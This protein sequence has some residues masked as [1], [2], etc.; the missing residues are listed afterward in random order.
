M[1]Y[2]SRVWATCQEELVDPTSQIGMQ[3]RI[4]DTISLIGA[5]SI[6]GLIVLI[7]ARRTWYG[8]HDTGFSIPSLGQGESWGGVTKGDAVES[9][10][11]RIEVETEV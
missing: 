10:M 2:L 11:T 8:H 6:S 1:G 9:A 4:M 3:A 7:W 5:I